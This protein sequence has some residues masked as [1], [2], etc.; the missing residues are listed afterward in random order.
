MIFYYEVLLLNDEIIKKKK[1]W[2][3]RYRNNQAKIIRLQEKIE[4]LE[5][6]IISIKSPNYSNLPRGGA[7]VTIEELL[8]D[9]DNI[10]KRIEK[11][12]L[13]G[14]NIKQEI[15]E[16]IDTLEYPKQAEIL[17][18]LFVQGYS[19]DYIN[20]ILSYSTPYIYRLYSRALKTIKIP[21]IPSN[22]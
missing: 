3:Y 22:S 19:V 2:L 18:Y 5:A 17:E 1:L 14:M 20:E 4:N 15:L 8:S 12:K 6:R 11:L 10:N 13:K 21:G 16:A 7:P 9:I